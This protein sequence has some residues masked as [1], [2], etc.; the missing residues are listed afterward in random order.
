M[1]SEQRRPA[2]AAVV[3]AA[4]LALALA[5]CG[6]DGGTG[7]GGEGGS[8]AGAKTACEGVVRESYAEAVLS[9]GASAAYKLDK[10]LDAQ[11]QAGLQLLDCAVDA[12]RGPGLLVRLAGSET[13]GGG[14]R[15]NAP[16]PGEP[17]FTLGFGDRSE[18]TRWRAELTFRCDGTYRRSGSEKGLYFTVQVG[19]N[20][21]A[22][23]A[24]PAGSPKWTPE[25]WAR[26]AADTAQ[27]AARGPLGC[28]APVDWPTGEPVLTPAGGGNSAAGGEGSSSGGTSSPSGDGSSAS[29]TA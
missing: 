28:T 14:P 8:S 27:R 16:L 9:D 24:N 6:S 18:V 15:A 19:P 11:R 17:V 3:V 12:K 10:Q 1:M 7:E 4:A 25:H 26:L 21:S 29:P 13:P 2:A 20:A 5:G 22:E 23:Q